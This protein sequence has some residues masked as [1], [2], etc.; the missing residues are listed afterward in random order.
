M[1]P[2]R[3]TLGDKHKGRT[4]RFMYVN[5]WKGAPALVQQ[6]AGTDHELGIA[7]KLAG[8]AWKSEAGH[9]R[10]R[11][12]GSEGFRVVRME[13]RDIVHDRCRQGDEGVLV[14]Q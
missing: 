5:N 10:C 3:T 2:C 12:A 1:H 6:G 13:S 9:R 14:K 8:K 11:T 7:M 4:E